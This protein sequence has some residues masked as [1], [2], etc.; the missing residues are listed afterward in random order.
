MSNCCCV[1]FIGKFCTIEGGVVF[2]YMEFKMGSA[3]PTIK[4]FNQSDGSPYEGAGVV[5]PTCA[6]I[7]GCC[8]ASM[9]ITAEAGML[10]VGGDEFTDA[11]LEGKTVTVIFI[12]GISTIDFAPRNSVLPSPATITFGTPTVIS[13]GDTLSFLFG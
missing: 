3:T 8:A 11:S 5:E 6:D 9:E 13:V 7:G 2:G 4:Y 1:E 12:N 10:N